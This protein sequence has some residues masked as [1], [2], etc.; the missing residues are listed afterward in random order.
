MKIILPILVLSSLVFSSCSKDDDGPKD[1]T[2]IMEARSFKPENVTITPG[3][4]VTWRNESGLKHNVQT[5]DSSWFSP[6]LIMGESYSKTFDD[7]GEVDVLCFYHKSSMT[8]T[9]N[10]EE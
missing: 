10:V 8:G 3:S 2:I 9:I 4:T 5:P 6:D 7:V 1:I